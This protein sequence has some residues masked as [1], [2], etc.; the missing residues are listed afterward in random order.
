MMLWLSYV[1]WL[2]VNE[3]LYEIL[4]N[5]YEKLSTYTTIMVKKKY[6]LLH[7]KTFILSR[8]ILFEGKI[9]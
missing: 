8:I 5:F 4:G 3:V 7:F 2:L 6:N 9:A 1:Q